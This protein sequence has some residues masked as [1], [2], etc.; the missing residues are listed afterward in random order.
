MTKTFIHPSDVLVF[1]DFLVHDRVNKDVYEIINSE[2][3]INSM[4]L[5]SKACQELL[6][7]LLKT[8]ELVRWLY[9]DN[10]SE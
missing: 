5:S 6:V 2:W 3:T 7:S 9:S 10:G 1:L 4:L 8:D